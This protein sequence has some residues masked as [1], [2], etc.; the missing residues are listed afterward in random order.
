MVTDT[1]IPDTDLAPNAWHVNQCVL[2]HDCLDEYPLLDVI[3]DYIHCSELSAQ[4]GAQ[5]CFGFDTLADVDEVT[6]IRIY[7]NGCTYTAGKLPEIEISWDNGSNWE[8]LQQCNL[9]VGGGGEEGETDNTWGS[10]SKTQSQL[11]AFAVRYTADCPVKNDGHRINRVYA[12]VWYTE[13]VEG[14]AAGKPLGVAPADIAKVMG[15]AIADIAK[16]KGV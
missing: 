16:V 14:W 4:D 10:L 6:Q 15:V 9:P 1:I 5:E 2:H 8:G 3:L 7:T 11:N 12:L 13:V